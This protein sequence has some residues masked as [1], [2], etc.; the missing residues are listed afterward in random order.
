MLVIAIVV[1]LFGE[2]CNPNCLYCYEK[3]KPY[4]LYRTATIFDTRQI[5]FHYA[6][7]GLFRSRCLE[8]NHCWLVRLTCVNC[9]MLL[10]CTKGQ[11]FL[12][13]KPMGPY[14]ITSGLDIFFEE[15]RSS[16]PTL[17]ELTIR[18]ASQTVLLLI[19]YASLQEEGVELV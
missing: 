3:R 16:L 14:L 10:G 4:G 18:M 17:I 9:L 13:S 1:R 11:F 12:E 7:D 19:L 15:S 8:E 2:S 6:K 5:P